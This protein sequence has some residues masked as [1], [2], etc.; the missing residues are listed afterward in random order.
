MSQ[1]NIST[2]RL[3]PATTFLPSDS[4]FF[5][6]IDSLELSQRIKLGD[7]AFFRQKNPDIFEANFLFNFCCIENASFEFIQQVVGLGVS[8]F[9]SGCALALE[10]KNYDLCLRLLKEYGKS[11]KIHLINNQFF[12]YTATWLN[13][14]SNKAT[15]ELLMLA[16][17][18]MP[19]HTQPLFRGDKCYCKVNALSYQV[20]YQHLLKML[21]GRV[22]AVEGDAEECILRIIVCLS[23]KKF[24]V[25]EYLVNLIKRY[26]L[27]YLFVNR[28]KPRQKLYEPAMADHQDLVLDKLDR[29]EVLGKK[30]NLYIELSRHFKIPESINAMMY[31]SLSDH[32]PKILPDPEQFDFLKN[33]DEQKKYCALHFFR[34]YLDY[35]RA[36]L[37]EKLGILLDDDD[38]NEQI[39]KI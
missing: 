30:M 36:L 20:I 25:P 18:L 31:K 1:I 21:L 27:A 2:S 17:E 7:I 37:H 9:D 26:G 33:L 4:Q 22:K 32:V 5:I 35:D 39:Q 24:P 10:N 15:H 23:H 13:L 14:A 28:L 6:D 29:V 38:F 16:I 12:N 34:K 19:N 8:V 3:I 11:K